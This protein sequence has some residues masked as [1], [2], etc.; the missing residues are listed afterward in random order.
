MFST[1]QKSLKVTYSQ[2]LSEFS[3]FSTGPTTTTLNRSF[4]KKES[5]EVQKSLGENE[6]LSGLIDA[7]GV[8]LLG[9]S[10]RYLPNK[11]HL[12]LIRDE[13]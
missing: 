1:G 12:T 9:I 5:L 10:N 13:V 2:L 3:T 4:K 11:K 6:S 7:S 8:I